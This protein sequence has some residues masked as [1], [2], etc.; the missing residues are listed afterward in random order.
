MAIFLLSVRMFR[1]VEILSHSGKLE[2][3]PNSMFG[4]IT[5]EV[6]HQSDTSS[7]E[8]LPQLLIG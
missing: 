8:Q 4:G 7:N 5:Y 1:I 2:L 6:K 3:S